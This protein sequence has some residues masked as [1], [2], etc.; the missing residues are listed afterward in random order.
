MTRSTVAL[1]LCAGLAGCGT[2]ESHASP[3]RRNAAFTVA[4]GGDVLLGRG[5]ATRAKREGWSHLLQGAATSLR[6]ADVALVNLESPLSHCLPGGTVR[7]PRL[8]G[9]PRGVAALRAA[10]IDA[11]TLAN[12]H[13]LDAG[14]AG[15]RRTARLLRR[16]GIT[17]LGV[18][19]ALTG[20]PRVERVG[21]LAVV[22]V[23]LTPPALSPGARVPVP[24]PAAVARALRS[25]R[26]GPVILVAHL[27][28]EYDR[29]PGPRERAYGRA[30]V[31]AGAAAVILHGAHVRRALVYD[32]GTPVHLGL[33][34]L[35]FD[36]RDPRTRIGAV[37][38]LRIAPRGRAQVTGQR[39]VDTRRARLIPCP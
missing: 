34:N 7:T 27:G 11:V 21:Q 5:V 24:S 13:A 9:D 8:C 22:A 23:N 29:H 19:A 37:V 1:L 26:P 39:C 36:Q 3:R 30:A 31:S 2:P 12:N 18:S 16:A 33:G 17:P 4:L 35:L 10:G 20:R 15:L 14:P 38:T 25:A 6:A 28:R 32:R